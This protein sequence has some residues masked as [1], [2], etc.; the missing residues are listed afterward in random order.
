M[1]ITLPS[2]SSLQGPRR[3]RE[4]GGGRGGAAEDDAQDAARHQR[5]QE[6][7]PDRAFPSGRRVRGR[8]AR[9]G[10]EA[11]AAG[12]TASPEEA[13]PIGGSPGTQ[14]NR[15]LVLWTIFGAQFKDILYCFG[16]ILSLFGPSLGRLMQFC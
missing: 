16:R 6:D 8:R 13:A 10:Q 2:S 15:H 3:G 1:I 5:P 12:R 9:A 11:E 7:R 4:R 14:F